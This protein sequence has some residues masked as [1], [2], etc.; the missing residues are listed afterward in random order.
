MSEAPA[1]NQLNDEPVTPYRLAGCLTG[2]SF[3]R[4]SAW[5]PGRPVKPTRLLTPSW[6]SSS[7][8]AS[9]RSVSERPRA[10]RSTLVGLL[11]GVVAG[12][13]AVGLGQVEDAV[14]AVGV[15]EVGDR[16]AGDQVVGVGVQAP[17]A[18]GR[19]LAA[20]LL[21]VGGDRGST[22]TSPKAA[23][24]VETYS[25]SPSFSHVGAPSS[26]CSVR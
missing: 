19:Q 16:G 17:A 21:H 12:D 10:W 6:S 13:P 2:A 24:C 1:R 22:G 7:Q 8:V 11:V 4:P 20:D 18:G 26:G 23:G 9:T 5:F 25:A 15:H 14:D 3:T